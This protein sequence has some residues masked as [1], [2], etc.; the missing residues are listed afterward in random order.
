MSTNPVTSGN[1]Y[2]MVMFGRRLT[3]TEIEAY[4]HVDP[5]LARRVRVIRIP[6]IPGGYTGMTL[7]TWVL[8]THPVSDDGSSA[9]MAHELVHVRQWAESGRIRF[10]RRYLTSFLQELRVERAWKAAYFLIEAE[11]EART[12]TDRWRERKTGGAGRSL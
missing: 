3:E 7:G 12:E 8:M 2:P 10:A 4:D 9:L 11:R 5:I 6:G 1:T